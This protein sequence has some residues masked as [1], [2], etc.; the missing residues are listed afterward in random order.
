MA[1]KDTTKQTEDV[2]DR[3]R[4]AQEAQERVAYKLAKAM[5]SLSETALKDL[6]KNLRK[7]AK[8]TGALND[9]QLT[10]IKS[11]DDLIDALD[12]QEQQ[13][14]K[15]IKALDDQMKDLT[16]TI[17]K[18]EGLVAHYE[19]RGNKQ[20]AE[21]IRLRTEVLK[22]EVTALDV[23]KKGIQGFKTQAEALFQSAEKLNDFQKYVDLSTGA[24]K[25]WVAKTL[26]ATKS[27]EL[28]KAALSHAIDEL[29]AATAVGLQDSFSTIGYQAIKL[30]MSFEEFSEII[31]KNRDIVRQLGGGTEGIKRFGEILDKSSENLA[32]MG[33]D[34]VKA[35][36]RFIES[37]KTMGVNVKSN[38]ADFNEALKQTQDEFTK[39][40]YIFGDT[41][42]QFADLM[43]AQMNGATI[44]A[45][46]TGLNQTQLAQIRQEVYLRTENLKKIG[47][48]NDQIKEFGDRIDA[49]FDPKKNIERQKIQQAESFKNLLTQLQAMQPEN[50]DL[51]NATAALRTYAEMVEGG[52]TPDQIEQY[53]SEN[54]AAFKTYQAALD[55][56]TQKQAEL[57]KSGRK[58]DALMF[59]HAAN[60]MQGA[61]GDVANVAGMAGAAAVKGERTGVAI[62]DEAFKQ[63]GESAMKLKTEQDLL[64]KTVMMARDVQQQWNAI[65]NTSIGIAGVGVAVAFA[66]IAYKGLRLEKA[67]DELITKIRSGAAG[68]RGGGSPDGGKKGG[69]LKSKLM[70]GLGAGMIG[71]AASLGLGY[72]SEKLV[73]GGHE[74]LGGT[75]DMLGTAAGW[76]GTGAMLGS[77]IPGVGTLAGGAIGGLA[78]GAYG[79]Y[80]NWGKMFPTNTA[81]T[82]PTAPAAPTPMSAASSIPTSPS[83]VPSPGSDL[84]MSELRKQ[85]QILMEIAQ[86]TATAF[87]AGPDKKMFKESA[88]IVANSVG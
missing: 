12:Q 82:A 23:Q 43:E 36:A 8:D 58:E 60:I 67:F 22:G 44:Q 29:N 66:A 20:K 3:L 24:L 13:F 86:N 87:R 5:E 38:S 34:G 71:G 18:Q 52:A 77:F 61:A 53:I 54:A 30:K 45:K 21:E 42:E 69:G 28:M 73:A 31:A 85:T 72:A 70:R 6:D 10:L 41:A 81:I 51:A 56:N 15:T 75:A 4:R 57:F 27:W 76:A 46:L 47:M 55:K 25:G 39:F 83:A 80:Q 49:A 63:Q 16:K 37:M 19:A 74:Q 17:T 2:F 59:Q 32:Y 9:E 7:L 79:A 35:T 14:E 26:T 33:K 50:K 84:A 65:M 78:G 68:V 62:A 88:A 64:T 1:A 48:S 11:T 40:N